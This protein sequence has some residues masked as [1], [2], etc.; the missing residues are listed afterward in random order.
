MR[1]PPKFVNFF[2]SR[3]AIN[4]AYA[5]RQVELVRLGNPTAHPGNL[6]LQRPDRR[7]IVAPGSNYVPPR[8]WRFYLKLSAWATVTLAAILFPG[9]SMAQSQTETLDAPNPLPAVVLHN[10]AFDALHPSSSASD[11]NLSFESK[12]NRFELPSPNPEKNDFYA[13]IDTSP[14]QG[15]HIDLAP[16]L[17]RMDR[18]GDDPATAANERY[19]WKGLLWESFAFF[20]VE[21]FQRLMADPYFRHLTA[22]E[23]FWHDYIASLKHWNW[24]RWDDGD[25]FLVA[26]IAHPMQGS[27]TEFIEIQND[28]RGRGLRMGD[29]RPYWRSQF[30]AFLWATVYSFDQKLGPLGETALGSEGGYT[31]VVGCP[32][33]CTAYRPGIDKVTN[34][35]GIVKLVSTPVVGSLW[36]LMEDGIDRL[37]SDR[38]QDRYGN[39]VFVKIIRGSLN[40]CR[41]MANTL[42]WR[43][44]WYR[45]FAYVQGTGKLTRDP[46][47]LPGDDEA[48]LSA[49]RLEVFPHFNAVSLPVNT[50]ACTACR[51]MTYGIGVGFSSRMATYADLDSDVSYQPNASPLPSDRAGGNVMIGTFGL[52]SG[53]QNAHF[54]LKASVR[55]GFVSYGQ[56]YQSSPSAT[57]PTPTMGR[58]THFATSL[59][60]NG[61]YF[62]NR[63]FA[64]RF[65]AG[66]LAV[67][68]REPYLQPA[69]IVPGA[70]P[71]L[72]WISKQTF[73]TNENWTYQTGAVLRF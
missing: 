68:Y 25:D 19:H 34:N 17:R 51:K 58:V 61:D 7:A 6:T 64:L 43:L 28:P 55:P 57:N 2:S 4:V 60:L 50:A 37:I 9:P 20:G 72:R 13:E 69:N 54:A 1:E 49:P 18:P 29:G 15:I 22:N 62:V 45:D 63:H 65:V 41:T 10:S 66:N 36:T 56:A 35:T 46:H 40:P 30:H 39:R 16:V 71:Y 44:P 47:W 33:P 67:R 3:A 8:V 32:Y 11:S 48:I 52:R 38:L 21:N 27:V 42:R 24:R 14:A 53:Y 31:Y 59:A 26:Y 73:L 12:P 5:P 23:P 70:Y